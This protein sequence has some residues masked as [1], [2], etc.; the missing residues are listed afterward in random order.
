VTVAVAAYAGLVID[1]SFWPLA[2]LNLVALTAQ[3]ALMPL[4][5]TITL[6]VARS[7]GL[8]YGRIR[9]WGSVSFML[10]SVASGAVLAS[11]SA[12]RVLALVLGAS[13][14]VL[15]ACLWVPPA[16]PRPGV[17]R[18]L[19]ISAVAA[20]VRFWIF[21][22]SAS[23]LQASH[24]LYYGFGTLYWRSLGLSDTIIGWLWAE[25][26]LA[27]IILFWHGR[28]LLAR[29]GPIG[30]MV[31]GATAGILRWSLSAALTSLPSI[32]VLQLLHAFTFGASHL[33]AMHFLSRAVPP[34]AAASAQSL[35]AAT[36]S[37][38]GGGLVMV[39]AG[40]LYAAYGGGAYLFMA[41]LSAAGLLGS[42]AR[43]GDERS[44]EPLA[45]LRVWF[46]E[47][48]WHD[49]FATWSPQPPR[50]P[51]IGLRQ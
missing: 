13:I 6:G 48:S 32:A 45:P 3:S 4:G 25:G 36:S 19:G 22:F 47:G 29:L 16:H 31:V 39:F 30:L 49:P 46:E 37:G 9:L 12:E 41:A 2:L 33:G 34:S 35:Y 44:S 18:I 27:E 51:I 11:S 50:R 8:E 17:K 24:Q 10:A 38:L 40:A 26:V 5:D 23:A 43:P 15:L 20:D 21:V 14:L 7:E 42:G 1:T 28:W